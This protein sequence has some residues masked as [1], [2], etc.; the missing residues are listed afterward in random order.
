M[1]S[2]NVTAQNPDPKSDTC[3][4]PAKQ[5]AKPNPAAGSHSSPHSHSWDVWGRKDLCIPL[6]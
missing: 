2:L 5:W 1:A 6:Y 4:H 3:R